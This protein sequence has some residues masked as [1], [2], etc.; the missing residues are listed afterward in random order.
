MSSGSAASTTRPSSGM[1]TRCESGRTSSTFRRG[2]D[3]VRTRERVS[4][5]GRFSMAHGASTAAKN[6]SPRHHRQLPEHQ[7]E[8]SNEGE[9][10]EKSKRGS[11]TCAQERVADKS[12]LREE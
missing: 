8:R 9:V 7:Y 10:Q 11:P 2:L 5:S 1:T 12:V 6:S 4:R 3:G